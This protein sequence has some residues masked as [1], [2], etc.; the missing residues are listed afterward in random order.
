MPATRSLLSAAFAGL[1]A[2]PLAASAA[3]AQLSDSVN[4]RQPSWTLTGSLETLHVNPEWGSGPALAIRR[5]LGSRWGVEL[6]TALPAFGSAGVGGGAIDLAVTYTSIN[7][8]NEV[9]GALGA[10]GFL[11]GDHSELLGGGIGLYVGAHA[12]RW[13]A[14]GVGLTA[15]ANL[16][17]ANG[18]FPGVH[19]GVAVRF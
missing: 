3:T 7:A 1:L 10:T 15:G 16:R 6:R 9:G 4:R 12:T 17:M 18:A 19:G 8:S 2:S 13:V 14:H 5:D 11:V